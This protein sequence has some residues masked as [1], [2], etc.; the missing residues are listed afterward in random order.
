MKKAQPGILQAVPRQ[1]RYLMFSF[2][3]GGGVGETLETFAAT[4]DGEETVVG[5][6][7]SLVHHLNGNIPGLGVFP[8]RSVN[9][10]DVPSTPYVLCCWLRGDDR[11]ELVH[12]TRRIRRQ[13][14]PAFHCEQVIDAFQYGPSLDLTGYEDGTENPQDE[15]A[16]KAALVQGGQPGLN[17]SSFLALQQWVHD[18]DR[19]QAMPTGAQDDSIGR[20][21]SDNEE[22]DDAPDSAHVKHTA[23]EDFEP[24]AFILR[25]SMPWANEHHEGLMFAAFGH[26]FAAFE[27]LLERMLGMDD[28]ITDALFDFTRPVTGSY[29]WCPPVHDGRLDL[30][31]M[32]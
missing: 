22:L 12:R 14:E 20:R 29:F 15:D 2:R 4:V 5:L 3:P 26:S 27:A 23:Q 31:A 32:G 9:G 17:G 24:E 8:A 25:R 7:L 1:A 10:I 13:L 11:G 30:R 18:L 19:F 6:G 21:K 28:G 16:V